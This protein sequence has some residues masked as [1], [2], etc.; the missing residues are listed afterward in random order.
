MYIIKKKM[1]RVGFFSPLRWSPG[2]VIMV[3]IVT[4]LVILSFLA[5]ISFRSKVFL[6][7]L[8]AFIFL[9]FFILM[10]KGLEI[11]EPAKIEN[12]DENEGIVIKEILPDEAG[13]V[14][15]GNETWSAYS[16]ENIKVGETVKII[17]KD[18]LF[19]EVKKKV[20]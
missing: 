4:A 15:I 5:Y 18:G 3:I 1:K 2:S 9:E 7:S 8:A 6:F 12:K 19:L 11:I 14:K 20:K 10:I 16:E 17:K 13:V